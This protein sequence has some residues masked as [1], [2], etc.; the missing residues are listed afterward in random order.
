MSMNAT[1]K[2]PTAE[3]IISRKEM[4]RKA[5]EMNESGGLHLVEKQFGLDIVQAPVKPASER[6]SFI[7]ESVGLRHSA[8]EREACSD[9]IGRS[10]PMRNIFEMIEAVAKSDANILITG[11]SGT[12]KELIA[13]AIHR[14]SH[15]AGGPYVKVNCA[16]LPKDMIESEI[17]GHTRG[18]FTGAQRDK[19]GLI[20]QA[21]GGSLLLDEIAEMPLELQPKLMRAL[22]EK[23]YYRLGS[24]RPVEVDF[25]LICATNRNP[26]DAM[27][28]HQL[29]ED[30]YYRISTITIEAPPL[31]ERAE[32]VQLLADHFLKRFSDRYDKQ[33]QA[34]SQSAIQ[35]MLNY[36]WPGNVREL[37]GVIERAV[38]LS[39][40]DEI[41]ASDLPFVT[42][43]V[44]AIAS[45]REFVLP[46]NMKLKDIERKVILQTLQRA[47]GNKQAAANILGIYRPR[48]YSLI[49]KH[50]L[51]EFM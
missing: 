49:R 47:K 38:L 39:K 22:Q 44:S 9:I 40:S 6:H 31:R 13:N 2:A 48:L 24:D 25:R 43:S 8:Q 29:R 1:E 19:K 23:A 32:D 33:I 34:F 26:P 37:E 15:R 10:E 16:A 11:E 5:V 50:N 36:N 27:R 20:A 28:N 51:T 7:K 41:E 17:F 3:A 12:G 4:G 21:D 35:A 30:I 14:N 45:Q 46:P 18:A 42:T